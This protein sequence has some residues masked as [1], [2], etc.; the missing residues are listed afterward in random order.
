MHS[1]A[2]ADE[3]LR[4]D[5]ARAAEAAAQPLPEGSTWHVFGGAELEPHL[6][7]TTVIDAKWL[8]ELAERNGVVPPWQLV[9][10]EAKVSLQQ[11]RQSTM[12][13]LLPI[14]VLS[15]GWAAKAHP[16]EA[17]VQLQRL[18][19]VLRTMVK[20]CKKG[21]DP[22]EPED[23]RPCVWGVVWDFLALPQRGYTTGYDADLDDRTPYERSR[24]D[25]GIKAINR[26]YAAPHVTTLV[27][28]L[29][30]PDGAQNAA[31]IDKRGWCVFERRLSS[32]TKTRS[33]CCLALS[34]LP[35]G[36]GGAES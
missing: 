31:P 29:P 5:E 1:T 7:H 3:R 17:G 9:P 25:R 6:A 24:F 34:L 20:S 26:W 12:N 27:L 15:Y 35:S 19:P 16:D 11:L 4:E 28:D 10:P 36:Q 8:L 32:I 13:G 30:M 2:P 14:A 22:D 18:V 33:A 21:I 23:G